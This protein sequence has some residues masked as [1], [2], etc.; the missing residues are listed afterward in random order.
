[1]RLSLISTLLL[2]PFAASH[3]QS[4]ERARDLGIPLDGTPGKYNAITDVRGVKVGHSTI[5]RGSGPLVVGQGPVRT[6]VTAIYP[7]SDSILQP[8]FAGWFSLN[9]NGE[10]TGTAW[11]EEYGELLYPVLITNTNSVGT[12][13]DAVI[14]WGMKRVTEDAWNCCLPVVAET[15]DGSLSDIF[16]F[17]VQKQHV[18]AALDSARSGPVQEGNVGG[19]TGMECLG[20][21]GGIGTSS[22]LVAM[23]TDTFTV[24]V[25]VQC[26]FGSR[27]QLRIAGIPMGREIT[28]PPDCYDTRGPLDSAQARFR[29]PDVRGD[30]GPYDPDRPG[31]VPEDHGSIIAIVATDAPLLPHQLKRIA[32]RVSLGIG[33]MGGVAG[34]SSGDL[35]LAFSTAP[36]EPNEGLILNQRMVHDNLISPLYTATVQATEEA[37]LNA[38]LA[39]ETMVGANSLRV[40]A[41]PH[42]QVRAILRKYNLSRQ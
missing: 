1:M 17:H 36:A 14:E 39:A 3:A 13:R 30:A 27:S 15:W 20:W 18:F 10:M 24:G 22:R 4:H 26:N 38:M 19:G 31:P 37:I 2:L 35:F 23:G 11:I 25:L 32:K 42:D 9:G 28:A 29:C 7:G 8:V 5:I 34:S 21:K 40:T 12:V 33:R 41:L 16:G 6:G